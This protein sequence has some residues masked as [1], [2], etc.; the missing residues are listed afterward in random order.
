MS[1]PGAGAKEVLPGGRV[2]EPCVSSLL[3]LI[4]RK[5]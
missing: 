5:R 2:P 3:L 4:G 1:D